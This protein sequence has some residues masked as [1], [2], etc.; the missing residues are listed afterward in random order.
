MAVFLGIDGG[1]TRCSAALADENGRILARAD[2]GAANITSNPETARRNIM[3][4]AT[5]V[6]TDA[7]GTA[8]GYHKTPGLYVAMGL[9][10]ASIPDSVANLCAHL[11]FQ[12]LR[13]VTDGI[14]AVKGALHDED[15]I[16]AAIGTG[17]VFAQQKSGNIREIGGR[18]LVFG[19][20]GSGGWLGRALLA[21]CLRAIDGLCDLTPLLQSTITECG[22]LERII[23]FGTS[24]SAADF[25]RF[26][27]RVIT[28]T[29][30]AARSLMYRAKTDIN[31]AIDVLQ[32][33]PPLPVVFLGG[34]GQ[35]IAPQFAD[36]WAIQSPRG[37]ALDGALWLARHMQAVE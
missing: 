23:T 35:I 28:S 36:K 21:D 29:D 10:G 27:S 3:N 22:G 2:G 12:N 19:D 25:A 34:I 6:M 17:S 8:D 30:P 1:G 32:T 4:V 37:S 7:F 15:G 18:G 26:A 24:A 11:P 9:A 13:V 31:A 14:T 20:E 5:T 33:D 16:V